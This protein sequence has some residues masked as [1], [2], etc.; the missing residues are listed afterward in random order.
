[1]KKQASVFASLLALGLIGCASAPEPRATSEVDKAYV[2]AVERKARSMGV[3]VQWI[4]PPRR[5]RQQVEE[6]G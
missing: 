6:E 2:G 1:M 4:N 3:D 5:A